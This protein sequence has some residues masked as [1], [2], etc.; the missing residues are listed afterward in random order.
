MLSQEDVERA[1]D[2]VIGTQE[3]WQV[4]LVHPSGRT[5]WTI[6]YTTSGRFRTMTI[7]VDSDTTEADAQRLID[8]RL[9]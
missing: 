2:R 5:A 6:S 1:A 7:P 9:P 3:G 8:E 4:M